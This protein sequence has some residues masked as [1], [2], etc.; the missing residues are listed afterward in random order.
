MNL[1]TARSMR[2]AREV[3]VRKAVGAGKRSLVGQFMGESLLLVFIAF[4]LAMGL[5]AAALPVFNGLTEKSVAIADLHDSTLLLFAGI[6]L[7]TALISGTYPALY[8]SSFDAVRIL[9]GTFRLDGGSARLRKGLVVFQFSMSILLVIG[10][11]TVYQQ[12]RY[13]HSKHLGLD[14]ENVIYLSLEGQMGEQFDTIKEELLRR[15]GIASVSSASSSPLDIGS[16][17]HS[18]SWQGKDPDREIEMYILT[19]SFDF[20]D[21]MKIELAEGRDFD[22]GFGTDS[23]TYILNEKARQVIGFEHPL[24]ERLSLWGGGDAGTVVGVV[25]DFH[26]SSLYSEIEPTIIRLRP[27][28]AGRLFLRTEPGRTHDALVSLEEV[29]DRFNPESPFEYQFLDET[30]HQTY[31]SEVVIGKLAGYFTVVAL[32]IACLGLFGLAAFTA[33]QRTKEIGVRKVFGATVSN[34]VLLLSKDF[35]AL[36]LIA[37]V[38]AVPLAYIAMQRWLEG[39]AYRI[40]IGPSVFILVGAAVLLIALLTVGYQSVRAALA[41]PVKSLRYE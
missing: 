17:T 10:T 23:V 32:F 2:R 24:G 8:L 14:R 25:K 36:V 12:I 39:F 34:L 15:P 11:V 22:P 6:G 26:M 20:L 37:F 9:R 3:G 19:V 35:V 28:D 29:Y 27:Q 18:V 21:V 13:I 33:Q 41:D 38:G 31:R 40:E 1:A 16:S 7:L 5:V 30:F 4:V